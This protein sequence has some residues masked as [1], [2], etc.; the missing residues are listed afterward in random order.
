[1]N[2]N[3]LYWENRIRKLSQKPQ[4]NRA[5]I[6]KAQRNLRKIQSQNLIFSENQSII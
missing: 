5:L 1:M 3:E 4:E 2:R 6:A